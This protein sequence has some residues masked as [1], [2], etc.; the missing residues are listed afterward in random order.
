[1]NI[2]DVV[3]KRDRPLKNLARHP[4]DDLM[5]FVALVLRQPRRYPYDQQ[6]RLHDCQSCGEKTCVAIPCIMVDGVP[7]LS[8]LPG[9]VLSVETYPQISVT[10]TERT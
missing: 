4:S 7:F 1:M 8:G 10:S 3:P 2:A 5:S 9:N 6:A